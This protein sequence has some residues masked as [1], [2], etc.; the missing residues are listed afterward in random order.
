MFRHLH[1]TDSDLLQLTV[2]QDGVVDEKASIVPVLGVEGHAQETPLIS[3]PWCGQHFPAHVQERLLQPA[4]IR[5]VNPH[6]AHLLCN[7]HPM[8]VITTVQHK[9]RVPET[10]GNL[11]QAQL[12]TPFRVFYHLAQVAVEVS[13]LQ[14]IGVAVV[15]VRQF[16]HAAESG[17]IP[18]SSVPQQVVPS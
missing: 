9:Y 13:A 14:N 12:E 17:H 8:C 5:Q 1:F 16:D 6:K 4:A 18:L 2:D 7:E 10:I 3:Q 11:C 15:K